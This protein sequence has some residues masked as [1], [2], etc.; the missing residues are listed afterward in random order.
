[1]L[2]QLL[3]DLT[4]RAR[5]QGLTDAEWSRRAG[6]RKETLSRLRKR[7]DCDLRTL[8]ALAREVGATL[9]IGDA[10]PVSKAAFPVTLG[11]DDEARLLALAARGPANAHAWASAGSPD[12]MAGLAVLLA[13]ARGSERPRWLALAEQL[14]P[15]ATDPDAFQAW[16]QRSPLRPSRFLPMLEA[17]RHH[18]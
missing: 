13:G 2:N 1:M 12:F 9:A 7:N 18:A 5:A 15:G 10:L 14:Q 6:L 8:R 17:T 11:R 4:V 16:L 3:D